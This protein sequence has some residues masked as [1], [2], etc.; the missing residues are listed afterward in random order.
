M[1][2]HDFWATGEFYIIGFIA[3]HMASPH[4]FFLEK[5]SAYSP[6]FLIVQKYVQKLIAP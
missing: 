3:K 6:L 2:S 5:K 1:Q 4:A